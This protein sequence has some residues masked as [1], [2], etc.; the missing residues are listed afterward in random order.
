MPTN[1]SPTLD[2]TGNPTLIT[3]TQDVTA[4]DNLGTLVSAILATGADGNPITDADTG[5]VEGIAV[6][7]VNNTNGKWQYSTDGGNNWIDFAVSKTSAT[8]LR[9]TEKIRFFPNPG[10]NGMAEITFRA[11]DASDSNVSGTTGVDPG[12]GGNTTAYS[13]ATETARIAIAPLVGLRP[14]SIVTGD[15]DKD[16]KLDLVTAN[17]SS[18]TV[19]VL[20]GKGDGAFNPASNLS[21]VGFNGLS[22]SSIAVADFN[23]DGKWD[24]VTANNVSNNISVLFGNGN[25]S[26]QVAVNFALELASAPTSV[27]VGVCLRVSVSAHIRCSGRLQWR[28]KI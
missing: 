22:P 9:D 11:W 3:I 16:G 10:Y 28:W 8:L 24:L 23:K 25:G 7:G 27:A 4:A 19:S 5:A 17:K 26:F 14:Y 12:V 13:T 21:I 20:L 6:I 15:F 18:S 2:N 1:T